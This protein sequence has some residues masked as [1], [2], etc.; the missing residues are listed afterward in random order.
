MASR[1]RRR[2][3]VASLASVFTLVAIAPAAHAQRAKDEHATAIEGWVQAVEQHTPGTEDGAAAMLGTLPADQVRLLR[4]ALPM[5]LGFLRGKLPPNEFVALRIAGAAKKA[6]SGSG[7]VAFLERAVVLNSDTAIFRLTSPK[8]ASASTGGRGGL[9]LAKD[10][11]VVGQRD[12]D[13]NWIVARE[14]ADA[15][16]AMEPQNPFV[17]DWYHAASSVMLGTRQYGETRDHFA[18]ADEI[19]PLDARVLL[20]RGC[21]AEIQGLPLTQQLYDESFQSARRTR[22]VSGGAISGPV[23]PRVSQTNAAAEGFLTRALSVD[24]T[25]VEARVRLS[26]L[27]EVRGRHDEALGEAETAVRALGAEPSPDRRLLFYAHLFASRSSRALGRLDVAAAHVEN[28]IGLFPDAQSALLEESQIAL[29]LADATR[30]VS[31]VDHLS[32][33][34]D[35]IHANADPWWDYDLGPGRDANAI[36]ASLR[37]YLAPPKR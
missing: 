3:L 16:R 33:V 9:V 30:A 8:A 14:L 1:P 31:A 4:E 17:S 12:L 21:E 7:A 22:T 24:P 25:L 23:V 32:A 10:G 11:Q 2:M 13:W 5:F 6:A 26:R 28:A 20:D 35:P 15:V 27:L 29:L 18:R 19:M 37:E 34:H 36:L